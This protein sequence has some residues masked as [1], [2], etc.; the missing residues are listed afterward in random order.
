MVMVLIYWTEAYKLVKKN[1]EP[2]VVAS[3]DNGLEVYVEKTK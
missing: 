3:K 2:L 1:A